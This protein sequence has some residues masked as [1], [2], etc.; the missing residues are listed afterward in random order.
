MITLMIPSCYA[1]TAYSV[2]CLWANGTEHA[3]DDFR[4][5][6]SVAAD[7]YGWLA[8]YSSYYS[9]EPTYS[10]LSSSRLGTSNAFFINSHA[11]SSLI[12][13]AARNSSSYLTGI[14]TAGDGTKTTNGIY[15][16][17]GVTKENIINTKEVSEINLLTEK[18]K[19]DN[20]KAKKIKEA[21]T[22]GVLKTSNILD[23]NNCIKRS[24]ITEKVLD[25]NEKYYYDFNTEELSYIL[26]TYKT[27]DNIT[28]DGNQIIIKLN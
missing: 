15:T 20:N 14:C 18:T 6:A 11:N 19:F 4:Q 24:A 27:D 28:S 25:Y 16:L 17:A 23:S 7:A 26:T 3:G 1:A 13:T 2:G 12:A 10:Y 5:N 9:H 22:K 21:D 8:G